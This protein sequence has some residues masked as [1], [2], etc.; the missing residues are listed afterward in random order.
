MKKLT[1]ILIVIL[2]SCITQKFVSI[3]QFDSPTDYSRDF[4][5]SVTAKYYSN[6]NNIWWS[7]NGT[8]T[9]FAN[10]DTASRLITKESFNFTTPF[11]ISLEAKWQPADMA[12]ICPSW[13]YPVNDNDGFLVREFDLVEGALDKVVMTAHIGEDGYG[14]HNIYQKEININPQVWNKYKMKVTEWYA[15]WWVNGKKVHQVN[16]CK[17]GIGKHDYYLRI[18]IIMTKRLKD[19]SLPGVARMDVRNIK[20]KQ[21]DF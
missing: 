12:L 10:R 20:I 5:D 16:F 21:F 15:K 3:K 6:H 11:E 7:D 14:K 9:L 4:D 18:S 2:C 17:D 8:F 1:I 19:D 13:T